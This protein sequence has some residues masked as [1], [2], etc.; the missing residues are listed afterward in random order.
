MST[1]TPAPT[2]QVPPHR[3]LNSRPARM[4]PIG[5]LSLSGIGFSL[6]V[7]QSISPKHKNYQNQTNPFWRPISKKKN[8]LYP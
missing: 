8:H 5:M 2:K 3:P 7:K 1:I 6:F 4:L